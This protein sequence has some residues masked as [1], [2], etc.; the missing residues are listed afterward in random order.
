M[1]P[2]NAPIASVCVHAVSLR[3]GPRAIV[4]SFT[5]RLKLK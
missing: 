3:T 4:N 5:L 1:H 2:L